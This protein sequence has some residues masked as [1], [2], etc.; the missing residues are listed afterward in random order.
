VTEI[1]IKIKV[2]EE[3]IITE[4]E[5]DQKIAKYINDHSILEPGLVL[6]EN[7]TPVGL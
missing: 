4:T 3:P 5:D 1:Y 2:M 6:A 7:G